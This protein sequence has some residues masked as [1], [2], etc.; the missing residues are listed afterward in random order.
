M[1]SA[2]LSF[3]AILVF[4][5]GF[6]LDF[7]CRRAIEFPCNFTDVSYGTSGLIT[8]GLKKQ[9]D[10]SML[11]DIIMFSSDVIESTSTD[12]PVSGGP[13]SLGQRIIHGKEYS[14][15]AETFVD[16]TLERTIHGRGGFSSTPRKAWDDNHWATT[17]F[18][19]CNTSCNTS[20][21]LGGSPGGPKRD[22]SHIFDALAM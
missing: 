18:L 20:C 16:A 6:V 14:T 19:S 15:C 8:L 10:S 4:A 13:L 9:R 2:S 22:R 5:F 12:H 7:R 11:G 3:S 21:N 17:V 1:A